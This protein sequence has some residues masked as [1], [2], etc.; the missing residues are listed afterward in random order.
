MSVPSP[1][2]VAIYVR[3]DIR[4]EINNQKGKESYNEFLTRKLHLGGKK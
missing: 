1:R 4:N 3:Y 2:Y